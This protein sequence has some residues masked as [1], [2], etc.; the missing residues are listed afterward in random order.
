M[1]VTNECV[2]LVVGQHI[3]YYQGYLLCFAE[4]LF[5]ERF[6]LDLTGEAKYVKTC[7]EMGISPTT[8]FIKHIQDRELKMKFHGLGPQ[9]MKALAVPLQVCIY[10]KS[11]ISNPSYFLQINPS[12]LRERTDSFGYF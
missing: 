6:D 11:F 7:E 1:R 8:Y 5:P 4:W 9:R 12:N 3:G 10:L 2:F